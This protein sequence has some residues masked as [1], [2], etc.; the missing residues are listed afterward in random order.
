[1]KIKR[2]IQPIRAIVERIIEKMD[3][4]SNHPTG[5]SGVASGFVL[6][7]AYT[8]GFQNADLILVAALSGVGRT[9]FLISMALQM[10]SKHK[11]SLAV[12]SLNYSGERIGQMCLSN[13]SN[14]ERQQILKGKLST[15][16]SVRITDARFDLAESRIFIFDSPNM[17]MEEIS[18]KA[19]WLIKE[20][21]IDILLI[22]SFELINKESRFDNSEL[23]KSLKILAR[24]LD[25][26]IVVCYSLNQDLNKFS[27]FYGTRLKAADFKEL[28]EIA[29]DVDLFCLLHRP[30]CFRVYEDENGVCTIG[31]A[32]MLV[33]T[34]IDDEP[35]IIKLKADVAHAKFSDFEDH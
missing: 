27:K 35:E 28:I 29:S 8:C 15:E 33:S 11:T 13:L 19:H 17:S 16:E 24:E 12:F 9:A 5:L 23:A 3:K 30:E 26:P 6:L 7:D 34:F 32:E 2:E 1:M 20:L 4:A 14:I 25:I 10:S 31:T 18:D 21:G 22:D